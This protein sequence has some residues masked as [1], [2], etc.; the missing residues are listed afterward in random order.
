MN[1]YA[2]ELQNYKRGTWAFPEYQGATR[3]LTRGETRRLL[4]RLRQGDRSVI[5]T[6]IEANVQL[7]LK[8]AGNAV[9][10]EIWDESKYTTAEDVLAAALLG[11][12]KA[13][14]RL[15]PKRGWDSIASYASDFI[16]GEIRRELTMR[17]EGKDETDPPDLLFS[18]LEDMYGSDFDEKL[19]LFDASLDERELMELRDVMEKCCKEPGDI[20]LVELRLAGHSFEDIEHELG[21]RHQQLAIAIGD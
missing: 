8:L 3:N 17:P 1:P 9:H 4:K 5:T 7:A 18:V 14:N 16:A 21:C 13:A 10:R 15:K 19:N 6:L 20:E 12:V 2:I 11:L